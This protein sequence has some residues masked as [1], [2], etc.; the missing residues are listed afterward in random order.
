MED[1]VT[2]AICLE[3]AGKSKAQDALRCFEKIRYERVRR[4]Q[5]T[6]E[7]TRDKWH[8]ADF[9]RIKENPESL[10]LVREA[11]LLNFDAETHA[12]DVWDETFKSVISDIQVA[13]NATRD[14]AVAQTVEVK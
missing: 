14:S 2:A 11:W 13:E 8:K 10:R 12:Y 6:G 5:K 7:T 9:D 3:L 4:A 1:G